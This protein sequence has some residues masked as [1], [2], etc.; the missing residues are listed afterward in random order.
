[1]PKRSLR[2][3]KWLNQTPAI[4][5]CTACS[6]QFKVPLTELTKTKDAQIYLQE[7]FDKHKCKPVDSSKKALPRQQN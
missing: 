1:M 5:V 3:I 2:V 4:A 6:R 7:Q